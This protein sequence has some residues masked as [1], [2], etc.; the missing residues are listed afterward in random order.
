MPEEHPPIE[1]SVPITSG[2]A[3]QR[4][5]CLR[6]G[7]R[8]A[9]P[10]VAKSRRNCGTPPAYVC[11]MT[12]TRIDPESCPKAAVPRRR[13]WVDRGDHQ[14]AD[15]GLPELAVRTGDQN[16]AAC[17]HSSC[18]YGP[19]PP[20]SIKRSM[21]SSSTGSGTDP[22][23]RTASWKARILNAGPSAFSAFSRDETIASSPR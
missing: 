23:S 7:W 8:N 9:S 2:T 15:R 1:L 14:R 11:G 6:H 19:F 5:R 12:A 4:T 21:C 10:S 13:L 17:A 20:A 18:G 3:R 22:S 16:C